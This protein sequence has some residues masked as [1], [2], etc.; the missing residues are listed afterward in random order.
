MEKNH[1]LR[2]F[3]S[4]FARKFWHLLRQLPTRTDRT[5]KK[6]KH[7]IN[8]TIWSLLAL[9]LGVLLLVQLP[10]FQS[11]LGEKVASVVSEK[12]GTRVNVGNVDL[13]F[14]NRLTIDDLLIYDQNDTEMLRARRV[15]VKMNILSLLEGRIDISSAQLFGVNAKFYKAD[16]LS[17]PNYQFFLD[18]LASND[19][20]SH[21]PLNLRM[22]SII[23]RH[24]NIDY[25]QND[26]PE[27]PGVLNLQHLKLSDISAHVSLK[28]LQEDSLNINIKRLAFQ[29]QSGLKVNRMSMHVEANEHQAEIHPFELQLPH[30]TIKTDTIRATYDIARLSESLVF[31]T[32]MQTTTLTL[33]DFAFFL[34]Q[35]ESFNQQLSIST[36]ISGTAHSLECP[37]LNIGSDDHSLSLNAS[38]WLRDIDTHPVWN[39]RV[40]NLDVTNTML[41]HCQQIFNE[42]PEEVLRLGNVHLRGQASNTETNS[43]DSHCQIQTDLGNIDLLFSINGNRH[44]KGHLNTQYL[45]L[46]KLL[47]NTEFGLLA[48]EININGTRDSINAEGSVNHFEYKDYAYQNIQINA[49][50]LQGYLS[51]KLKIDDPNIQSDV[52]GELEYGKHSS[53][54]L[55]GY[56]RNM[57]PK[58]L[59]LTNRWGDSR[60]SAII[61]ADFMATNLNDAEGSIDIDDFEMIAS[62]TVEN[63]YH[64]DNIHIKTG[65]NNQIHFVKLKGDMG[66]AEIYGIFDW[67]TLPQSFINYTASKLP[68]LPGLPKASQEAKNNFTA[69]LTLSDTEWLQ[70]LLGIPLYLER[71]LHLSA[72]V[73]DTYKKIDMKGHIPMFTYNGNF[74]RNANIDISTHE[75]TMAYQVNLTKVM[76]NEGLM[77][78]QVSGKAADNNLSAAL[79]WNQSNVANPEK[80]MHGTINTVTQLYTN[81]EGKPEAH[82]RVL[83]SQMMVRGTP[84]NLEPCDIIYSSQRLMVDHFSINHGRQHLVIDGIASANPYDEIIVDLNELEVGYILDLVNFH[85]VRFE[86]LA[87]GRAYA[88]QCFADFSARAELAVDKFHFEQGS[89]GVLM[90]KVQWN[91]EDQQIDIQAVADDG[92]DTQTFIEGYISPVR[93]DM[94][95]RFNARGTSIAFC[96]S[97]TNTFLDQVQGHADGDLQLHGSLKALELTGQLVVDGQATVKALNTTYSLQNDTVTFVPGDILFSQCVFKDKEGHEGILTGALHHRHLSGITFDIDVNATNLLA[98][99][100]PEFGN[101]IICGTVYATGTAD[102]H[103]RPGEIVINCNVTPQAN[104]TFA[105]NAANPDAIIQQEFITWNQSQN[106]KTT[107]KTSLANATNIYINFTINATP[108]GTL[109]VLMDSQT[110][111]YITLNGSGVLKATFYNKGP[112]HMF[113]TYTVERGT[114]G[115]TIQNIIKKNFNF[116]DRGT[117]VFGGDPLNANLNLQAQYT[118]N[119]A[120]LSDLNL[121]NSFSNNTVRVNCLMN[122]QGTPGSPQVEFDF[123]L[124]SVN[125]EENQMI[126]SLIASQQEMNQQ[127]LYLLAIGRFYTQGAN[128][129]ESQQYG[130]TQLAMQSFL[131]GTVSSQINEVLSQVIKSNDWNFGA[132]ISTGN[133]GWHNAEYEG[134]FSGR[135]LNNRLLINGQFGY[136]D[137]ATQANPSFI[138]DFDIQYLLNPNGNLA[139]KVYNQTNDRYFTRSSLNTQGVGLIMKKDFNGFSDLFRSHK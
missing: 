85:S 93:N 46:G 138:G 33:T 53:V 55:T 47:D 65:F 136:R 113:G 71:P 60:F 127:V 74:Y 64:L 131:S 62:D 7:I 51:G 9:Y 3:C 16:S 121:G 15:S 90:A 37:E 59:N 83:P 110:N 49:T 92:P 125:S 112:F 73:N 11:F 123:E 8:W 97:F 82:L 36:T 48:S 89:M 34:P 95:L 98:Y 75:D 61:D 99:N 27:T 91:K 56:I 5:V 80:D 52:E 137:N 116:Q 104:S 21:H 19:T 88:S 57:H 4:K 132:N 23:I 94:D 54:R 79:H 106:K 39:I 124:P 126:R 119:G 50:C 70:K 129:A 69:T 22:N 78:L 24:S 29:E 77:D 105:Y 67:N 1:V 115:I 111:D 31:E 20:T 42:I 86:G 103:G 81:Q 63:C 12:L 38:G 96:N 100:F 120:S 101:S 134:V 32:S 130:Q 107:S 45:Q 41:T 128:N 30:S 102:L 114:Y 58:N 10:F 84:W 18:A 133:E 68:T 109:R 14:L 17:A 44:F 6:L 108:A 76:D 35:L 28:R 13:G 40:G 72:T 122:I 2:N 25:D 118:V 66:E 139:L 26:L 135:M 117:I 87:T 43:I